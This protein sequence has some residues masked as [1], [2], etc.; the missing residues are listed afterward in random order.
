MVSVL[1][2]AWAVCAFKNLMLDISVP[3][4]CAINFCKETCVISAG[5]NFA[6]LCSDGTVVEEN[7][8]CPPLKVSVNSPFEKPYT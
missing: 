4:P 7:E 6:C 3:N 1:C 8:V 2:L 5:G